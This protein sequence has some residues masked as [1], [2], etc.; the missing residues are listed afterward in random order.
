[1]CGSDRSAEQVWRV[2]GVLVVSLVGLVRAC[3][4]TNAFQL[5]N[6]AQ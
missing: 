3:D 1:M 2:L 4:E 5:A 6:A